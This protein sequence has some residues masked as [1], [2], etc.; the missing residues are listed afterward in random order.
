MIFG[1]GVFHLG[2]PFICVR[3]TFQ[4]ILTSSC[5]GM[6]K[7][8]IS[9]VAGKSSCIVFRYSRKCR[10]AGNQPDLKPRVLARV[11]VVI[12][13][14]VVVCGEPPAVQCPSCFR[15][16]QEAVWRDWRLFLSSGAWWWEGEHSGRE[17]PGACWPLRWGTAPSSSRAGSSATNEK[18]GNKVA[19]DHA[20]HLSLSKSC[21]WWQ[22]RIRPKSCVLVKPCAEHELCIT[23]FVRCNHLMAPFDL[24]QSSLAVAQHCVAVVFVM[25]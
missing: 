5:W 1:Y 15:V 11:V 17:N 4:V 6:P 24:V 21:E 20:Q 13:P 22:S 18:E 2:R 25:E 8:L 7:I 10:W 3:M 9:I 23:P 14:S 12:L 16:I 19:R